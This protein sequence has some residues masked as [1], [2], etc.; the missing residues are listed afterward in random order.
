MLLKC[1][2]G[3]R[4][5]NTG[6]VF[7]TKDEVIAEGVKISDKKTFDALPKQFVGM[8]D[9]ATSFDM[10]IDGNTGFLT[11]DAVLARSGVQDYLSSELGEPGTGVVGVFRPPE[12]VRDNKS[13]KTFTNS[14]VTDNHPN[15]MVTVDNI[16]KYGKGSISSVNVVQLDGETALATKLTVTDK[17]L[18]QSN[19]EGKKELSVGYTCVLVQKDGTYKGKDYKYIQ[20]NII[21]NHV[22]VVDAG[23]CGGICKMLVDN[24]I[25]KG[26]NDMIIV[27]GGVEY[28]VPDEVA[29]EFK[30]LTASKDEGET[31]EGENKEAM[32]KLQATVDSHVSTIATLKKDVKTNDV[33]GVVSTLVDEKI[34]LIKLADNIDKVTVKVTDSNIDIKKAIVVG[35]GH[36][37]TGK[38]EVYL[39]AHIDIKTVELADK[40]TRKIAALDS[41]KNLDDSTKVTKTMDAAAVAELE[42]KEMGAE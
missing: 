16:K 15:E 19:K 10:V 2:D 26:V 3:Y 11:V 25:K 29:A 22:A 1:K 37:V 30:K 6:K 17:D 32:D 31:K 39:D 8:K 27:I 20:T 18:I 12:E 7:A 34:K 14:P 41:H 5:G 35:L 13:V 23:R 9:S 21:A 24:K 36:D 38:S 28:D 42:N 40:E 33:D 4:W